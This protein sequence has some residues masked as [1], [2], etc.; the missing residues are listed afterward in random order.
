MCFYNKF[1][2]VKNC[3]I[4]SATATATKKKD[5]LTSPHVTQVSHWK[6]HERHI[7]CNYVHIISKYVHISKYV[8]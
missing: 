6:Q 3:T 2:R 8:T 7:I 4:P 5:V 1:D